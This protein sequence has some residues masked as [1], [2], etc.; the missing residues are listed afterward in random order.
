MKEI[1][2]TYDEKNIRTTIKKYEQKNPET[3][4]TYT[5]TKIIVNVPCLFKGFRINQRLAE[6]GFTTFP[7]GMAN[8]M[9][10]HGFKYDYRTGNWVRR[11]NGVATHVVTTDSDGNSHQEDEYSEQYG[12]TVAMSRA[13]VK[14]QEAAAEIMGEFKGLFDIISG[15]FTEAYIEFSDNLQDERKALENAEKT[16]FCGDNHN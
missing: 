8:I 15:M 13:K 12:F 4:E 16:G 9:N 11:I 6:L 1:R 2:L 5:K 10:R 14:A 3:G 7:E